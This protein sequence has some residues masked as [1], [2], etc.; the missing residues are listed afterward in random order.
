MFDEVEI[1]NKLPKLN[2]S[3][4]EKIDDLTFRATNSK[5]ED[6]ILRFIKLCSAKELT[7]GKEYTFR[8]L[9]KKSETELEFNY[10]FMLP[11]KSSNSSSSSS[12]AAS[13]S[14][15]DEDFTSFDDLVNVPKK[16]FSKPLLAKVKTFI[17]CQFY[18]EFFI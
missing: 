12:V 6:C 16:F 5:N 10:S 15:S 18:N 4:K 8:A 1:G 9:V 2:L 13:S 11:V 7:V 14:F 17:F 3:I